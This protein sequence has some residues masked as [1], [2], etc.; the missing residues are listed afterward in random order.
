[1]KD[2]CPICQLPIRKAPEGQ[3]Y[4]IISG[5]DRCYRLGFE[6]L[7]AA[8]ATG[9]VVTGRYRDGNGMVYLTVAFECMQSLPGVGAMVRITREAS[10]G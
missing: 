9:Q 5:G 2:V 7:N 10:R 8:G 1:M 4:C 3:A 6:R